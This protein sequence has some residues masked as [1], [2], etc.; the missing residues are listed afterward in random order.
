MVSFQIVSAVD[1]VTW[2]RGG[3]KSYRAAYLSE[4]QVGVIDMLTTIRDT[5]L[6]RPKENILIAWFLQLPLYILGFLVL[7]IVTFVVVFIFTLYDLLLTFSFAA[8]ATHVPT[9][10]VPMPQYYEF[11]HAP[12]LLILGSLFG[13]IHCA[14]WYFPF[15]TYVEQKLWRIA[16]LAVTIIPIG[17]VVAGF[18]IANVILL[19]FA[20]V[21]FMKLYPLGSGVNAGRVAGGVTIPLCILMYMAA[22]VVLLGLALELLRNQPPSAYLAVD[23]TRFYPHVL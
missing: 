21:R 6:C 17:G 12:L 13:G 1:D 2:Q 22:R 3:G 18:I 14:G 8:D 20:I 7:P 23:W 9:F 19:F 16:S 10:Y 11:S 15:P 5:L 4:L